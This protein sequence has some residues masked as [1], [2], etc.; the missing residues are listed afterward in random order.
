[1]IDSQELVGAFSIP[2]NPDEPTSDSPPI[3]QQ[4]SVKPTKDSPPKN[5]KFLFYP[6]SGIY[7]IMP[8]CTICILAR[9]TFGTDLAV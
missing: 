3:K 2:D 9:V 4:V 1:M 5:S 8:W 6:T 7:S